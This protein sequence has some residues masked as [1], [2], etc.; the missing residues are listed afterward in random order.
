MEEAKLNTVQKMKLFAGERLLVKLGLLG[1]V[2]AV[3]I[4]VFIGLNGV[5]VGREGNLMSAFS[6]MRH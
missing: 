4:A 5:A 1:L 2:L 3:I 6:L